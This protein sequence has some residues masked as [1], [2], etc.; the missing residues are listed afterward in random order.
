MRWPTEIGD[1]TEQAYAR[2]DLFQKRRGLMDEWAAFCSRP[3]PAEDDN[4]V[5]LRATAV[6]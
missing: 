1:E 2:G 5:E 3:L 4:V 6:A